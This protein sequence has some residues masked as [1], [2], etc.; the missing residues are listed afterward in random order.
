VVLKEYLQV[1]DD[2][3][4]GKNL[5][6]VG[7]ITHFIVKA[8]VDELDIQN[9]RLQQ[10]VQIIVDAFPDKPLEGAVHYIASQADRDAFAKVEVRIHITDNR[11]LELKHNLSVRVQ[12][13][14]E[15]IPNAIGIPVKTVYRK[16]G[17]KAWVVTRG[18]LGLMD[19]KI[20][21]LGRSAGGTIEVL[22]GLR[23]GQSVGTKTAPTDLP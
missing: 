16:E 8:S 18:R 3:G 1:G 10:P 23:E 9:I 17:D 22:E 12:I 5:I 15:D 6:T 13:L 7:D 11:G 14:T 2:A 20:V 19:R 21:T 4:V